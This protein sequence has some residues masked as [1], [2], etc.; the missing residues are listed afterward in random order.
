[1]SHGMQTNERARPA[2]LLGYRIPVVHK[3]TLVESVLVVNAKSSFEA[4][5][6]AQDQGFITGEP[7][8][9]GPVLTASAPSPTSDATSSARRSSFRRMALGTVFILAACITLVIIRLPQSLE[10]AAQPTN[11]PGVPQIATQPRPVVQ[12]ALSEA[13]Q[14]TASAASDADQVASSTPTGPFAAITAAP[15]VPIDPPFR[16]NFVMVPVVGEI[17]KDVLASDIEACL[18]EAR[19][20]GIHNVVF[21]IDSPGGLVSEAY[22]ILT[23][24]GKYDDLTFFSHVTRA[25]SAAVVFPFSSKTIFV[26]TNS[27]FGAAVSFSGDASTG[28]ARVDAKFNSSWGARVAGVASMHGHSHHVA[29][30]MC[31]RSRELYAIGGAPDQRLILSDS[32]ATSPAVPCRHIDSTESVLALD[33]KTAID[34]QIAKPWSSLNLTGGPQE[35]AVG[36]MAELINARREERI[37]EA[38]ARHARELAA[39]EAAI[40]AAKTERARQ[41]ELAEAKLAVQRDLLLVGPLVTNAR[42]K[43]PRNFGD[44]ATIRDTASWTLRSQQLWKKRADE[45]INAWQEVQ[46]R[47]SKI[48][49]YMESSEI[50]DDVVLRTRV[51]RDYLEAKLEIERLRAIRLKPQ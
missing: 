24:L 34:L 10:K 15:D 44:Y 17:G 50:D 41:I 43:H 13:I 7:V 11:V 2:S 9:I 35:V 42:N 8:P 16:G 12:A 33:G 26:D 1:M 14:K 30:A 22:G 19:Q 47:L 25:M 21:Q 40:D 46:T 51:E 27:S 37:A 45:A 4:V 18:E 6:V 39:R 48:A 23:A 29:W 32:P 28:D 36:A 5:A 20:K 38:T 3:E 31:E 49:E